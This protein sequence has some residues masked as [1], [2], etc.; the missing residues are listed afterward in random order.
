VVKNVAGYD[1]NKLY[2]GSM[3]TLGVI[4]ELSFKLHPLPQRRGA[5]LGSFGDLASAATVVQRVMRSPLGP[6][7]IAVLD[8]EAAGRL[9]GAPEVGNAGGL[10]VVQVAGF[11]KAV[12]RVVAEIAEYCRE[13]GRAT[14]VEGEAEVGR[15]WSDVRELA[16]ATDPRQPVL[17]VAVPPARSVEALARLG[18]AAR[19]AGLGMRAAVYA[20][21]GLVY[22]RFEP[23]DWGEAELDRLAGLVREARAFAVAGGGSLVVEAAPVG[24]KQRVDSWGEIGPALGLMRS[25]KAKLDPTGTLNPGRYVGGI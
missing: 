10:L 6:A 14:V 16:D 1:L 20:G 3:G 25:L 5:V 15:I 7:S 8:A 24:L 17:K 22:G 11:E 18:E 21:S 13:G 9:D 23:A 12:A 19:S 4:V 2:T